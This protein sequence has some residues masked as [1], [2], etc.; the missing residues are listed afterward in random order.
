MS[1]G[2]VFKINKNMKRALNEQL[3]DLKF[4]EVK[5][6]TSTGTYTPTKTG[7]YKVPVSYEQ[8]VAMSF[9]EMKAYASVPRPI[10]KVD[11]KTCT[12]AVNRFRE[13]K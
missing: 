9:S 11:T 5:I 10:I 13:I 12:K 8:I 1:W 6:I 4:Q 2:E 7:L 3:R